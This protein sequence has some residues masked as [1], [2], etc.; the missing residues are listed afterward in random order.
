MAG[1]AGTHREFFA[2]R[3]RIASREASASLEIERAKPV[4][5]GEREDRQ[6]QKE[7]GD[8]HWIAKTTDHDM[9]A[10]FFLVRL[11]QVLRYSA[12]LWGGADVIQSTG[13]C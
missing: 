12:V 6:Q 8:F 2:A 3:L 1:T 4:A 7:R 10:H 13:R 11:F 9:K 5:G